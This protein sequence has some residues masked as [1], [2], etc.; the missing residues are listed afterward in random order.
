MDFERLIEGLVVDLLDERA[1][2]VVVAA[3][4]LSGLSGHRVAHRVRP[5]TRTRLDTN[6]LRRRRRPHA[7]LFV[8][9]LDHL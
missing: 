1:V 3:E 8:V 9:P 4:A 5:K 2:G 7:L 6:L